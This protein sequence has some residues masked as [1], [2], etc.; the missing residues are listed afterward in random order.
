MISYLDGLYISGLSIPR[1]IRIRVLHDT[2]LR[3][4]TPEMPHLW[5]PAQPLIRYIMRRRSGKRFCLRR[6]WLLI[7]S[8][9]NMGRWLNALVL[10]FATS[11]H[12]ISA[13]H[14]L[15]SLLSNGSVV[16]AVF[17]SLG[18]LRIGVEGLVC[19]VEDFAS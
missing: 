9:S 19:C 5:L 15:L 6:Q 7:L 13:V 10:P 2:A 4:S 8:S 11:N 17:E 3:S 12:V 18:V 1:Q 16:D 14:F